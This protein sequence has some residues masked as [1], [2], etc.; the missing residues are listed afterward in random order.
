MAVTASVDSVCMQFRHARC[1]FWCLLGC[2]L[3]LLAAG[4]MLLCTWRRCRTATKAKGT[5]A[6]PSRIPD[7]LDAFLVQP[8]VP[9]QQDEEVVDH[10]APAEPP[11]PA[12]VTPVNLHAAAE[13][14]WGADWQAR[15]SNEPKVFRLTGMSASEVG[16][17]SEQ[18][19]Q[20]TSSAG[21]CVALNR[22]LHGTVESGGASVRAT[23]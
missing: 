10:P 17:L 23:V 22:V 12:R 2:A 13:A 6:E 19:S 3:A 8:A 16:A 4:I 7:D 1:C 9:Q 20:R 15:A 14:V 21:E 5:N 11:S 18:V